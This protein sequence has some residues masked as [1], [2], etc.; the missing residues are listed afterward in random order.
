MITIIENPNPVKE[1][2]R[3]CDKCKCKFS[4]TLGDTRVESWNNGILGP[5]YYG[6]RREYIQC[7]NCGETITVS[8]ED[9]NSYKKDEWIDVGMEDLVETLRPHL[10][11]I[12]EDEEEDIVEIINNGTASKDQNTI[13]GK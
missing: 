3:T 11:D 5:G 13:I 7:P 2:I 9:S 1:E 10:P 6:Y 12:E 4:Y 8:S